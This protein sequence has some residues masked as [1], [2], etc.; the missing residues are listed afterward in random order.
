ME[1]MSLPIY[2][3]ISLYSG[4]GWKDDTRKGDVVFTYGRALPRPYG[5][6]QHPMVGCTIQCIFINSTDWQTR[7]ATLAE[8]IGL[9]P[10]IWNDLRG[11]S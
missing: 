4:D 10:K 3:S 2:R 6:G 8:I 9:L 5:E 1:R 11:K 7:K